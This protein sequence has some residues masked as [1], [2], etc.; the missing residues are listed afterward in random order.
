[1]A[2]IIIAGYLSLQNAVQAVDNGADGYVIKPLDLDSLLAQ[3]E[4][5]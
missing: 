2:K 4:N 1:M 3:S 5:N